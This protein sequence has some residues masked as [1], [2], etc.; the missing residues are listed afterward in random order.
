VASARRFGLPGVALVWT[1]RTTFD[2]I[3]LYLLAARLTR[4]GVSVGVRTRDAG[5]VLASVA[6]LALVVW[7]V[8]LGARAA[9]AL[10]IVLA[11]A[12]LGYRWFG[13]RLR[14][15]RFDALV[16]PGA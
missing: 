11:C 14:A 3:V 6:A 9:I 1:L 15:R 12:A 4:G 5:Y 7:P 8:G 10:A 13:S 2:L 16:T